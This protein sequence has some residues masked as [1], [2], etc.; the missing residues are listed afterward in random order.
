MA[1]VMRFQS[2]SKLSMLK[3]STLFQEKVVY[4]GHVATREGIHTDPEKVN[5]LKTWPV[6][7]LG[8]DVQQ[9]LGL[10]GYYRN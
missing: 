6:P 10:D 2:I 7:T 5:A 1:H 9:F 8:R 4:L 3:R